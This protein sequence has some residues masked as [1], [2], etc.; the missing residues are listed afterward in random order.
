MPAL[1]S[2]NK[3]YAVRREIIELNRTGVQVRGLSDYAIGVDGKLAETATGI[4]KAQD[5]LLRG[6]LRE[7][8]LHAEKIL[9]LV[10]S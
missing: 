8:T 5:L 9:L 4:R 10:P 7:A 3:W 1:A 2:Q 6:K